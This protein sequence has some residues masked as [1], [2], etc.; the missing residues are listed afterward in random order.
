[1]ND[2]VNASRSPILLAEDDPPNRKVTQLMLGRL[3]Y[4]ADS[5]AKSFMRITRYSGNV[6][7]LKYNAN[8]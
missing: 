8:L 5:V 7:L 3:G 1:M 2:N 4:E 6:S